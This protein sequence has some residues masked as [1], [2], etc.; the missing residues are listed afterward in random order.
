M[1]KPDEAACKETGLEVVLLET[2]QEWGVGWGGA[3]RAAGQVQHVPGEGHN[4][5]ADHSKYRHSPLSGAT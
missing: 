4:E 2:A 5:R 1:E 3:W